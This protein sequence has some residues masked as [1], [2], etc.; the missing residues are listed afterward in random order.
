MSRTGA[1]AVHLLFAVAL[2]CHASN[3]WCAEPATSLGIQAGHFKAEDAADGFG[4]AITTEVA[5]HRNFSLGLRLQHGVFTTALV[6]DGIEILDHPHD[7]RTWMVAPT[8]RVSFSGMTLRPF[9]A[10]GLG[11]VYAV[12]AS[13]SYSDAAYFG[14]AGIDIGPPAASYAVVV[15]AGGAYAG[16][17]TGHSSFFVVQIGLRLRFGGSD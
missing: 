8:L 14:F 5:I 12:V 2:F 9:F 11:W 15:E 4:F 13:S 10:G 6:R 3:L 7:A 17:Y 1:L 16:E